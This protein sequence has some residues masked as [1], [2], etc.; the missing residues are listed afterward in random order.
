[1]PSIGAVELTRVMRDIERA[2]KINN[3]FGPS[4][5]NY[6]QIADRSRFLRIHG[7]PRYHLPRDFAG[8]VWEDSASGDPPSWAYED[9]PHD[10]VEL[11]RDELKRSLEEVI[12]SHGSAGG[13]ILR[14]VPRR[15]RR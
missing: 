8:R 15:N 2:L 13:S 3:N 14:F 6:L 10:L 4:T 7:I 5:F 9:S 12:S 11:I 1:M